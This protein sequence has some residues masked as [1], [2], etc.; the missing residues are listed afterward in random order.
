MEKFGTSFTTRCAGDYPSPR[1]VSD[2]KKLTFVFDEDLFG[3]FQRGD[4]RKQEEVEIAIE[5]F[6]CDV[7]EIRASNGGGFDRRADFTQVRFDTRCANRDNKNDEYLILEIQDVANTDEIPAI[8]LPIE[9]DE[10]L[11]LKKRGSVAYIEWE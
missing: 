7:G 2:I 3:A 9:H 10:K 4:W 1:E 6:L 11:V 5:H 8:L